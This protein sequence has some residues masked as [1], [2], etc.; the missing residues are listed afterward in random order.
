MSNIR[1][2]LLYR[3]SILIVKA[4]KAAHV[5]DLPAGGEVVQLSE[6]DQIG[7]AVERLILEASRQL[8]QA[9]PQQAE[10]LLVE[11]ISRRNKRG[12]ADSSFECSKLTFEHYFGKA[13]ETSIW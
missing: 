13:L 7:L 8:Q 11:G 5:K 10:Y 12:V 2:T 4:L 1:N 9:Q 6:E 3:Y